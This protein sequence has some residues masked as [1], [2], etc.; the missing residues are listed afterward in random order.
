[1][2]PLPKIKLENNYSPF[3]QSNDHFFDES[4]PSM[5]LTKDYSQKCVNPERIN[6]VLNNIH[7]DYE[8]LKNK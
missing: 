8:T 1:M 7:Q 3:K 6:F 4:L 5:R 2:N